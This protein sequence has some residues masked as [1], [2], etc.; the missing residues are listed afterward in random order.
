MGASLRDLEAASAEMWK[1]YEMAYFQFCEARD[2]GDAARAEYLQSLID[3]AALC[4]LDAGAILRQDLTPPGL[5]GSNNVLRFPASQA[6]K[7]Q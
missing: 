5:A 1:A 6:L 4:V 3:F 7:K 2:K